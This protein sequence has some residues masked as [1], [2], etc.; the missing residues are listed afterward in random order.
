MED[1]MSDYEGIEE[2]SGVEIDMSVDPFDEVVEIEPIEESEEPSEEPESKSEEEKNGTVEATEEAAK[3]ESGEEGSEEEGEESES[4]DTEKADDEEPAIDLAKQIEEGS[5]ELEIGEEKVTLK[6][7]KNSYQGQKEIARRFTE[8][9]KKSKQLEADT[10]EING[11]INEF[12]GKLRDGDSI[13]AM[14]FFGD[15]AGV[16][17][18]MIKEQLIAAL[19]PEIIRREQMSASDIQ[20]EFLQNQNEYLQQQRESDI[21]RMEQSQAQQEAERHINSI[22]EANSIDEGTWSET[23]AYLKE[24]LPEGENATPELIAETI[25]YGRMYQQAE[26]VVES[27]GEQLDNKDKW[28]EELVNVK[29]KYPDFTEEDLNEVLKNA[30]EVSKNVSV[31][32]KL[33][34]KIEKMSPKKETKKL[35]PVK[36]QDLDPELEDWL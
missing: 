22:R 28:I 25:N 9:D 27:L 35:N 31:E 23:E 17:P 36:E 8:Y 14:Q 7:L 12:A 4:D 1:S 11:Y 3:E 24:T 30:I 6:D 26:G 19:R 20:N 29:E 18:Y 33:A 5:L 34:D 16:A 21:K 15:F 32:K 10:Q 2:A 13:G